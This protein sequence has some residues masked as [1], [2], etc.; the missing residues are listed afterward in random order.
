[1]MNKIIVCK[2]KGFTEEEFIA[3]CIE[4]R[5]QASVASYIGCS[6]KTLKACL[7]QYFPDKPPK[8]N[9]RA[10]FLERQ[11][12]SEC[13]KC[14]KFLPFC[15]FYPRKSISKGITSTCKTCTKSS[16][17]TWRKENPESVKESNDT[18]KL[19]N[20]EK[21]KIWG[22]KYNAKR[23][24]ALLNCQPPWV[25]ELEIL[26]IYEKCPVGYEVDHIV[27]LINSKVCGLHVPAN[28]QYLSA[29]ENRKKSNKFEA[30]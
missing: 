19:K 4:L 28:L 15:D 21:I 1:M 22:K 8:K 23:K 12:L 9:L 26:E 18:Y 3:L 20:P 6:P 2:G 7:D 29:E 30:E 5:T 17:N 16:V 25:N 13:S 11:G 27:P 14:K 10:F 24:A